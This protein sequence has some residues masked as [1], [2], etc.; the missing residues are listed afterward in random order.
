MKGLFLPSLLLISLL[1]AQTASPKTFWSNLHPYLGGELAL[2]DIRF[3]GQSLFSYP[4]DFWG[5]SIGANYIYHRSG[6]DFFAVGPGA[7][8][9]GS[10][11]FLGSFGSNWM[12]Q[13][14]VY[15]FARIGAAATP[16]N[17]QRL[18]AG[19]GLGLRYTSFQ[20]IYTASSGYVGRLRQ[21]FLNPTA[22]V[23]L[24]FNFRR[25]SPTTIRFYMDLLPAR[26]NTEIYGSFDPVPL[27]YRTL[28]FGIY[29]Y[30][31]NL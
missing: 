9:T 29:Y 24:T 6:D 23:E 11:Q 18:G 30:I 27:D 14:P 13:V 26:R 10:F 17:Q 21:N 19:I 8:I 15:S 2:I 3:L 7:Q 16:Y 4:A 20:T 31:P 25:V 28:G 22:M 1:Q 12:V 5:I